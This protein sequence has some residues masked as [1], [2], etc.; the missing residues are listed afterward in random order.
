LI[1]LLN[2]DDLDAYVVHA[3][4]S[5]EES[6]RD[7]DPYFGP[8]SIH[9]PFRAE[10]IRERTSERWKRLLS[11][12]GWRRAW[13][14]FDGEGIVGSASLSGGD[15]RTELHRAILGMAVL[16]THRG[17]GLGRALLEETIS[18][19]RLQPSIEWLDLGVFAD[20]LPA[21]ALYRK[22]GFEPVGQVIDRWRIDG[23]IVDEI[24]MTLRVGP[25]KESTKGRLE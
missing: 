13:G 15:L 14:A 22:Y 10:K 17:Q 11:Q 25:V 24:T 18:W 8:Y 19:C 2:L 20:N 7:G 21:Q 3:V 1:R 12:P 9:E 16:R 23:H 4:A 6:G 5:S